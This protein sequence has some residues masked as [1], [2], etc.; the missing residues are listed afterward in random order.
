MNYTEIATLFFAWF[1][2]SLIGEIFGRDIR[3][4]VRRKLSHHC[5]CE[6]IT[7]VHYQQRGNEWFDVCVSCERKIRQ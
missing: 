7:A 4:A 1:T 3:T 2:A 5:V 6:K